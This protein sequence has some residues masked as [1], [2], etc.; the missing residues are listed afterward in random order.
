M[1]VIESGGIAKF[2]PKI[3]ERDVM[4]V[5]GCDQD[6]AQEVARSVEAAVPD[7]VECSAIW[8]YVK[9]ELRKRNI[10]PR[11]PNPKIL[12]I[13]EQCNF[14]KASRLASEDVRKL[15]KNKSI[16]KVVVAIAA[17]EKPIVGE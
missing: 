16:K 9:E 2:N 1:I 17:A 3:I 10:S 12:K 14:E 15:I 13:L 4:R 8:N 6:K 11:Q 5:T 7:R